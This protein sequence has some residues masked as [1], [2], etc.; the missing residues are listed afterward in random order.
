MNMMII[1]LIKPKVPTQQW[2]LLLCKLEPLFVVS[3]PLG[4]QQGGRG[5][6]LLISVIL[7][8]LAGL[9]FVSVGVVFMKNTA[10]VCFCWT[11]MVLMVLFPGERANKQTRQNS[12]GEL[13]G[14]LTHVQRQGSSQS[15]REEKKR[16]E[17]EANHE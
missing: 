2:A 10:W 13:L 6:L 7:S 8:L 16:A 5:H 3:S 11:E 1:L 9:G 4:G 12:G 15:R 14:K 17:K